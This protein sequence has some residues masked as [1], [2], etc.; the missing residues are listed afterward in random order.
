MTDP[1]VPFGAATP[2]N[3]VEPPAEET[4]PPTP[5]APP[6]DTG[7]P[8][9]VRLGDRDVPISQIEEW[10]RGSMRQQDYTQKTQEL[11]TQKKEAEQALAMYEKV[12]SNPQVKALLDNLGNPP[13]T[14]DGTSANEERLSRIEAR[15]EAEEEARV[16][17]ALS[18][19]YAAVQER[20][21]NVNLDE[22]WSY[23]LS[24]GIPDPNA[25]YNAMMYEK[26][27]TS[28]RAEGANEAIKS[29]QNKQQIVN[30][31]LTPASTA[32]D[33]TFDP[34]KKSWGDI[35][36]LAAERLKDSLFTNE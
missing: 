8:T 5:A 25:A 7:T 1:I 35:S 24:T 20:D 2:G 30:A 21:P 27:V 16:N 28:A 22:L 36:A 3:Q 13:A 23:Q 14:E 11:A 32:P 33:P 17:A 31:P 4:A 10:E 9:V 18:A 19:A 29:I 6:A 12:N 34:T 26:D 15:L